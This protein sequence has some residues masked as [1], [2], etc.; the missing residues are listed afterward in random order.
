MTL[1][2]IRNDII[3]TFCHKDTFTREDFDAVDVGAEHD[4]QKEALVREAL[5]ELC[6]I[7]MARKVGDSDLWILT[8][9]LNARG[10]EVGL[11][12]E[13]CSEV[14][15]TVNAFLDGNDIEGPRVDALN[16]TEG[17]IVALYRIIAKELGQ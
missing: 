12:M 13:T 6:E 2:D 3:D 4:E 16:I 14:A 1:T 7:G 17:A 15:R 9:S 8:E 11:S 10:Q 5:A